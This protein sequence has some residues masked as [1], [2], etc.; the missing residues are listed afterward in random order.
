MKVS[1]SPYVF[2][3]L[4]DLNEYKKKHKFYRDRMTREEVLSI[5]SKSC[6]VTVN[7][8]VSRC[9]ERKSVDARY[10]FIAMMRSEFGYSLKEI[11]NMLNR[12]H[13]TILHALNTYHDRC[14]VYKDYHD[15]SKNILNE[16]KLNLQ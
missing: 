3:G 10:M 2:P 7:M 6:G 9:R 14:L 4:K 16:I 15:V 5:V 1:I 13:T 12:D 8:I 11:G